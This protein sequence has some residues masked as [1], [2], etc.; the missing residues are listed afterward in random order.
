MNYISLEQII[1]LIRSKRQA[2]L[3]NMCKLKS[4]FIKGKYTRTTCTVEIDLVMKFIKTNID[5]LLYKEFPHRGFLR[6]L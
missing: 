3:L 6:T 5:Q 2:G 4:R 1:F